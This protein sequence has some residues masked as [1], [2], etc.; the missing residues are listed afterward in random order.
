MLMHSEPRD[1]KGDIKRDLS[2]LGY[3]VSSSERESDTLKL[4]QIRY[5]VM[6]ISFC[7]FHSLS[8][9][10]WPQFAYRYL[11]CVNSYI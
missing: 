7:S 8:T 3:R 9:N 11:V 10:Q 2:S 1:T 6:L 5:K 4:M